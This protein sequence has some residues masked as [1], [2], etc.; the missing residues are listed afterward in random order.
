MAF[1]TEQNIELPGTTFNDCT[2]LTNISYMFYNM[3]NVKYTLTSKGFK[4]CKIINADYCFA[5]DS[6]AYIK[7][8]GVAYGLFYQEKMLQ[9]SFVGWNYANS[10]FIRNIEKFGINEW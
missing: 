6:S 1:P 5:E 9:K 4:N 7:I 2:K 10:N 3:T 8:G